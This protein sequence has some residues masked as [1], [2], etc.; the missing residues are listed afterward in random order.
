MIHTTTIITW[1]AV[2]CLA[3]W[4]HWLGIRVCLA[5]IPYRVQLLRGLRICRWKIV[6][7]LLQRQV[8]RSSSS[9]NPMQVYR[10]RGI[11]NREKNLDRRLL[12]RSK[13]LR[14]P[15]PAARLITTFKD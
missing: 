9:N 5:G 6:Y 10:S 7:P 3:G 15:L 4:I 2:Y 13:P 14:P 8:D 11:L 12:R 1:V